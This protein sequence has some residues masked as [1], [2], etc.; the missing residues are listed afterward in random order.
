LVVVEGH[1]ELAWLLAHLQW[2]VHNG[3]ITQ[4]NLLRTSVRLVIAESLLIIGPARG[5]FVRRQ[6]FLQ[7][8]VEMRCGSGVI[9]SYHCIQDLQGKLVVLIR[10]RV[11]GTRG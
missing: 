7:V 6:F 3:E 1:P 5:K 10:C 9:A 8:G 2:N 4:R 11:R